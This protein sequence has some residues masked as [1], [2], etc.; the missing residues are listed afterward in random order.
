MRPNRSHAAFEIHVKPGGKRGEAGIH[1]AGRTGEFS[2]RVI[3][4]SRNL[5]AKW[6][7]HPAEIRRLAMTEKPGGAVER[8]GRREG[9]R[10]QREQF[11]LGSGSLL[12]MSTHSRGGDLLP[13]KED[14]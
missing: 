14:A 1:G 11:H 4:D 13:S 3:G 12:R 5:A 6:G 7:R 9:A 10:G 8:E 2:Q